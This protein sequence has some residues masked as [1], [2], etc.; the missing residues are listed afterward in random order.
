MNATRRSAASASPKRERMDEDARHAERVGN[1]ACVLTPCSGKARELEKEFRMARLGPVRQMALRTLAA[2]CLAATLHPALAQGS[3]VQ[4]GFAGPLTGSS[5]NY[6]KD[7]EMGARLAVD[8]ANAAGIVVGGKPLQ[9]ALDSQDDEADPKMAVQIAQ[10]LV[11]S[12]V[13]AVVGHFNSGT[14][15][16]ASSVYNRAGIPQIIPAASNPSITHQGFKFMF[17]PYGT[18]NTVAGAAAEHAVQALHAE[19]ITII[20]DR[21]A[22]GSGLADEFEAAVKARGGQVIDRE[23]TTDKATDF[24]AILTNLR[25]QRADLVFVACLGGEGA[26]VVKQARELEYRG[27]LMA[28]ATFANKNFI[29]RAGAA[30]EGMYAFEQGIMLDQL[31]QGKAFLSRFHAKYGTDPIGFAPF[32]YND[33]WVIVNAMKAAN[34][35][36]PK[37]FGPAIAT[38]SFQGVLG[39]VEFNQFG[40]LKSPKTTL[41]Q[42]EK[43]SWVPVKTFSG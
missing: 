4:I 1:Q 9:L 19:R 28:G 14:T 21:T 31:P 12:D 8:E 43:G 25:A 41:F 17:R 24:K 27:A 18:D 11:D 13:V 30:S 2:L 37:V 6:G 26:L 20:D 34:S 33:V 39:T 38:L 36:D 22:Y 40:D 16:A 42:V 15:L 10:R 23:Y 35:T 32:A 29:S 5:A 3:S 7:L